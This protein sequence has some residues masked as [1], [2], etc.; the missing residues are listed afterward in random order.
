MLCRPLS[1]AIL[2]AEINRTDFFYPNTV[3]IK[4]KHGYWLKS[5]NS[6]VKCNTSGLWTPSPRPCSKIT[7]LKPIVDSS[8]TVTVEDNILGGRSVFGCA[9][10][11]SAVPFNF[12]SS[13]RASSKT[14]I[15]TCIAP[16]PNASEAIGRW[17][18]EDLDFDC[19][20]VVC[21]APA[22]T[23]NG[24]VVYENTTFGS[25]AH[26]IC[27]DGYTMS[28]SSSVARCT[29]SGTWSLM[30]KCFGEFALRFVLRTQNILFGC[31]TQC[32]QLT[33]SIPMF[34][35]QQTHKAAVDINN[36]F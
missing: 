13:E 2:F 1:G 8:K 18:P 12:S 35:G 11:H 4:C 5:T 23:E 29:E 33:P 10:G 24:F 27:H 15:K 20:L 31:T 3:E 19:E 7:C 34:P 25:V 17:F 16:G 30:P 26:Y 36:V 6:I 14:M 28:T 9:K 22:F 32:A 21:T